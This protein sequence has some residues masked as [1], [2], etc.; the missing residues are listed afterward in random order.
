MKYIFAYAMPYRWRLAV[1]GALYAVATACGL[2]MPYLMSDIVNQGI[3]QS[4]M[5]YILIRGGWMLGLALA[6]L[7]CGIAT[8]KL[9]AKVSTC[10]ANDLQK[11]VF[12]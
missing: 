3:A 10:F 1:V 2:L 6:A 7:L 4:Q 11:A 12:Q 5:D 8:T 9:N